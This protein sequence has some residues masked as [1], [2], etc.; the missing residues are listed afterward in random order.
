MLEMKWYNAGDYLGAKVKHEVDGASPHV[1]TGGPRASRDFP[2]R[3]LV[4][5]TFMRAAVK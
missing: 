2:H 3:N 1:K 5:D 4:G